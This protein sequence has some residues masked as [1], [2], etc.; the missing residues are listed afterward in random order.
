M[1]LYL[2]MDSVRKTLKKY[3]NCRLDSYLVHAYGQTFQGPFAAQAL[4]ENV[5]LKSTRASQI[6]GK[7]HYFRQSEGYFFKRQRL[8]SM[9]QDAIVSYSEGHL[10]PVQLDD[11]TLEAIEIREPLI[12]MLVAATDVHGDI[13]GMFDMALLLAV[14][15]G[16]RSE[17]TLI[18]R[19]GRSQDEVRA[20]IE[21]MEADALLARKVQDDEETFSLTSKSTEVFS[22]I[23]K[24]GLLQ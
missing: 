9:Y 8:A 24:T 13:L 14:Y 10:Q 22:I 16:A 19:L 7:S 4:A 23:Y 6:L 2:S 11:V 1:S 12:D 3:R 15:E 5:P 18:D 20:V 17:S 21:R